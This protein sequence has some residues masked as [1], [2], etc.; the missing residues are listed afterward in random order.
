[1]VYRKEQLN[2]QKSLRIFRAEIDERRRSVCKCGGVALLGMY[3]LLCNFAMDTRH[4]MR[5]YLVDQRGHPASPS[6]I[7]ETLHLPNVTTAQVATAIRQLSRLDLALIER[8]DFVQAWEAED[9][10]ERAVRARYEAKEAAKAE[11]A[12]RKR[13]QGPKGRPGLDTTPTAEDVHQDR[14]THAQ[15]SHTQP[16]AREGPYPGGESQTVRQRTE[17][18]QEHEREHERQQ[19]HET[20]NVRHTATARTETGNPG[21]T[22]SLGAQGARARPE[23]AQGHHGPPTNAA[24]ADGRDSRSPTETGRGEG[25]PS[26]P[27]PDRPDS[28]IGP[29]PA[30]SDA[31]QPGT[32]Q[33]PVII[34]IAGRT[35][36]PTAHVWEEVYCDK[37]YPYPWSACRDDHTGRSYGSVIYRALGLPINRKRAGQKFFRRERGTFASKWAMLLKLPIGLTDDQL[38]AFAEAGIEK[39][40]DIEAQW[41]AGHKG[42][43]GEI[44]NRGRVWNAWCKKMLQQI[45]TDGMV[46]AL[47]TRR[48]KPERGQE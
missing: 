36:K 8:V 48:V 13:S 47:K 38:L 11:Q 45:T 44:R 1:L 39:A 10:A 31:A 25:L 33:P 4:F 34:E 9:L 6:K 29:G 37:V 27:P 40:R 14:S 16:R 35:A 23:D 2:T 24:P 17:L 41:R 7:A 22:A 46:P 15:H 26:G 43:G 42:E 12:A 18:Q 20:Q 5:G 28:H 21:T 30:P 3:G 19:Q 32:Q